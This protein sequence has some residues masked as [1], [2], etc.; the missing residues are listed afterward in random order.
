M[1]DPEH[2]TRLLV[3]AS[4]GD[5]EAARDLLP[6]VYEQL[7]RAAQK[8]MFDE[9]EGH[10]LSATA[11]V[12]EAFVKIAGPRQIP[13]GG[14]AHF[15]AAAAQGM[16]QILID[17]ARKH[18]ARGG[19]RRPLTEIGDAACLV[20]S[21]PEQIQAVD[22]AIARLEKEDPE[23]ASVVRLRF[24]AGLTVDQ[25]AEALGMSPRS[26]GRL[27][28]YARAV[29]YRRLTEDDATPMT[30]YPP[31]RMF[32]ARSL[33]LDL[34]GLEPAEREAAVTA[35]CQTDLDLR[36]RLRLLFDAH[37]SAGDFLDSRGALLDP[38][39]VTDEHDSRERP[40]QTID[41]YTLVE[42]LG[43]GGFGTVW[44]AE[45]NAPVR[46]SVA[47]KIIKLG[48][49]TRQV[50][51]RFGAERQALAMMDHPAIAKVFDAGATETGRPYF[52]MELVRGMPITA[53]CDH[54]RLDTAQRLE[55]FIDV[56]HAIQHAHQ[57]G[58]IHRDIK[59][60]NVLVTLHD[61][62][63][64]PK[65]IDFGIAKA[66]NAELTQRTLFTEHHQVVGTPA[67]MSPEQ[68]E[69][70]GLDIDTRS[71]IYALGVLLYELLTGT[72]PFGRNELLE[73]GLAEMLRII[74]E[75]EPRRPST[76]LNALGPEAVR[77]AELR[78]S[79]PRRLAG[80]LRDDLDWIVMMCLEKERARR[81]AS[82]GELA[83]DIRRHLRK[84]PVLAGPP[85]ASY[86]VRKFVQRNRGQ[87]FA[88]TVILGL[89]VM[90]IVGTSVG[91]TRAIRALDRAVLAEAQA[92]LRA[93]E[94]ETVAAF[95][96]AQIQEFEPAVMGGGIRD[97]I[98]RQ[99]AV[100]GASKER[101]EEVAQDLKSI[102]FTNIALRS[103]DENMFERAIQTI[104]TQFSEQPSVQARLL[105]S[106]GVTMQLLGLLER[107]LPPI[108]ESLRIRRSTLGEQHP[109]TLTSM[110]YKAGLLE[111]LAR[112]DEAS[113]IIDRVLEARARIL[114]DEHPQTLQ[115]LNMSGWILRNTRRIEMA[116][117]VFRRSLDAHRRTHGDNHPDTLLAYDNLG[118]ILIDQR[119][120]EEAEGFV[121][122]ALEGRRR[123][124]GSAH[125]RTLHSVN[126][127]GVILREQGRH[128]E[129]ERVIS[130]GLRDSRIALGDL[131]PNTILTLTNLAYLKIL[132]ER[133]EEAEPILREALTA[134][135]LIQGDDHPFTL[136]VVNLLGLTLRELGRP[137]ESLVM[138][139]RAF[140]GQRLIVPPGHFD[141]INAAMQHALTLVALGRHEEALPFAVENY[142]GRLKNL[143][144]E[145]PNTRKAA[146]ILADL[147]ESWHAAEPDAGHDGPA[148]LWRSRSHPEPG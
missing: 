61:G 140:E 133:Y 117:S 129:A 10:T 85:S 112:Y 52:V 21:D 135:R 39:P 93:E 108:E 104:N 143:G 110:H 107:A 126:N 98:L 73:K 15:Y 60:S 67:Y 26:A 95:Q 76:R 63:A 54:E 84:E 109:D 69:M 91:M 25:A 32:R 136:R 124:L 11:L 22:D 144:A 78:R 70:S 75:Q 148:A 137:G 123:V 105:E 106:I 114:G 121:R 90:G 71:D 16:R 111:E 59:P 100:R 97:D 7:R 74:R 31:D 142:E 138:T 19:T 116:E 4:E 128:D 49:D 80:I 87:V 145:A 46:R 34:V 29:L 53:Y 77:T 101:I 12:H 146:Q 139:A 33:F 66:T 48:M 125:L 119:R 28:A 62:R 82:A 68:T 50:I 42:R 94:V 8:Q 14:R 141:R 44:L 83:E 17:H 47:L 56:C 58:V 2:A 35:A 37:D 102:N 103:L 41:R 120:Y 36:N 30:P 43:E 45:Q 18:Q 89:L 122:T 51:A 81:Y 23:A 55:L 6:L 132:L 72:T 86:R 24:Y 38:P 5:A 134:R 99:L 130:H 64:V 65:V 9:R 57:K 88:A 1:P 131:H 115:S 113:A 13:W 96:A 118:I 20:W 27:W 3:L 127:L 79:D 147:Y 40:G 92:A